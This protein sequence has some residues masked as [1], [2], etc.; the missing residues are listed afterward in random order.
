MNPIKRSVRSLLACALT[1][2]AITAPRASAQEPLSVRDLLAAVRV[3]HPLVRAAQARVDAARGARTTAG[4]FSNPELTYQSEN[5]AFPGRPAAP[6]LE[7]EVMTSV[8][9][10]LEPLYQRSPRVRRA[11]ADVR[12]AEAD[13]AEMRRHVV[14]DAARAYY[15]LAMAQVMT[16]ASRE[17][18]AWL[19][20][21]VAYTAHRVREGATAEADLIRLRVERDRAGSE[22]ALAEAE[23][24]R[25][26]ATVALLRTVPGGPAVLPAFALVATSTQ[27][28]SFLLIEQRS[29]TELM[30]RAREARADLGAMRARL[31]A[32]TASQGVERSLV[33]RNASVMAGSKSMA[34][35]RSFM[36]GFSVPLPLFDQNRGELRRTSGERE[37]AQHER[38]WLDQSVAAEVSGAFEAWRR[39]T[40]ET[41][42][43]R[44]GFLSRAEES[45]RIALSAYREGA[46]SLFDVIDATRNLVEARVTW[47]RA[48]FGQQQSAIELAT[49]VGSD[50]PAAFLRMHP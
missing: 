45:R 34:G 29:V 20:S 21:L 10:P 12:I 3:Q 47:S 39:L 6:G 7:R 4:A 16:D 37:A 48:L 25:E 8:M 33:L 38:D 23:F 27:D 15:R 28:S 13:L 49:A 22:A 46:T 17:A 35:V 36:A 30:Q 14:V 24:A 2:G 19:D 11:N 26:S 5:T 1:A 42:R 50:D 18:I 31:D 44:G 40:R 41:D 43:L 9:L 32:A